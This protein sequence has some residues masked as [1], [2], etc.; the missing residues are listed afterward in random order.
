MTR[1]RRLAVRKTARRLCDL[2]LMDESNLMFGVA[3][4]NASERE[5]VIYQFHEILS[6]SSLPLHFETSSD[7]DSVVMDIL[8]ATLHSPAT[9][10]FGVSYSDTGVLG[11]LIVCKHFFQDPLLKCRSSCDAYPNLSRGG[12]PQQLEA[13]AAAFETVRSK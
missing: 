3:T 10:I 7:R 12:A 9:I 5:F 13:V 4:K 8:H 6:T 11:I 2:Y 1:F